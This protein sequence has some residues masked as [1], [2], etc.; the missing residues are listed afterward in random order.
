MELTLPTCG[1]SRNN[2]S[3]YFLLATGLTS[4]DAKIQPQIY[5]TFTLENDEDK[6][7]VGNYGEHSTVSQEQ[8]SLGKDTC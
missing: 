4:K 3:H 7:T 1:D 8:I 6:K 5:N 2:A